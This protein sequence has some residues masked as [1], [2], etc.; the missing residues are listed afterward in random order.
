MITAVTTIFG[1]LVASLLLMLVRR[2][3]LHISHGVGWSVAIALSALLGFAP[4]I[5]DALASAIG[6]A[7]A[8]ILGVSIAIAALVTKALITDIELTKLRVKHHILV[9]KIALLDAN[10]KEHTRK[11]DVDEQSSAVLEYQAQVSST[12]TMDIAIQFSGHV[13]R[14]QR[15]R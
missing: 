13:I 2:D 11:P 6:I 8:P 14:I 10:I 9:Q 12:H 3:H 15:F 4:S 7:Y 1:L 5:F